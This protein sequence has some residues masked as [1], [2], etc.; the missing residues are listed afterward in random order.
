MAWF[1]A[2]FGGILIAATLL[3]HGFKK[4]PSEGEPFRFHHL[5]FGRRSLEERS[6]TQLLIE[7]ILLLLLS[8]NL[9][10]CKV[11]LLGAIELSRRS[12]DRL[13]SFV[14]RSV[15]PTQAISMDGVTPGI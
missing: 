14:R 4:E 12:P 13:S 8:I 3:F 11:F 6:R 7:G 2:A 1:V 10:L 9:V 5:F 15:H